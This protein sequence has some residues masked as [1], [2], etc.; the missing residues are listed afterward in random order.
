M[1]IFD[2]LRRTYVTFMM[3]V[4]GRSLA[5]ASRVDPVLQAE[6]AIL[7][8]GF[9]LCMVVLPSGPGMVVRAN[10]DGTV[11]LSRPSG[12]KP[13]LSIR[14]KHL[15]HAFR[16]LSFQEGTARALANNRMVA[17]GDVALATRLVRCLDRMESL[18]LPA[19]VA[20]R[21]VKRYLP[22]RLSEKFPMAMRIYG[23]VLLGAF[24]GP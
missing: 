20:R 23:R 5:A 8:A 24:K 6:L 10:G 19:F 2:G 4:V 17:D 14:F 3:Q 7:P 9:E 15:E 18:I 12:A 11:N 1:T 21:A 22:V 16:V 13:H